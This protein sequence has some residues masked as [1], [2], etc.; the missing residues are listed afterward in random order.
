M[1]TKI[2]IFILFLLIQYGVKANNEIIRIPLN[3][4]TYQNIQTKYGIIDY[5]FYFSQEE[6]AQYPLLLSEYIIKNIKNLSLYDQKKKY[7]YIFGKNKDIAKLSFDTDVAA[8]LADHNQIL[9]ELFYQ[10]KYIN[11]KILSIGRN[12]QGELYKFYGGTPQNLIMNLNKYT[13][14]ID[15]VISEIEVYF[16]WKKT[17]NIYNIKLNSTEHNKIEF[18]DDTRLNCLS[19]EIFSILQNLLFYKYLKC[20]HTYNSNFNK[21]QMFDITDIDKNSFPEIKF[22]MGNKTIILDKNNLIFQDKIKYERIKNSEI[23]NHNYLFIKNSPCD[24]N[25]F[26]LKFLKQFNIREYNLETKELNLY[27]GKNNN[28]IKDENETIL[29]FNSYSY[30]SFF[31]LFLIIIV[32]I[33]KFYINVNKIKYNIYLNDYIEI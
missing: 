16:D 30:V 18:K 1:M 19:H 11:K 14:K 9:C 5:Q 27:L 10:T 6:G 33:I 2:I 28:L 8:E 17:N 29:K 20:E 24:K 26:G 15:D 12:E 21:Y 22:K 13:F 3:N 4:V 23:Q 25:I 31:I 32:T 7:I